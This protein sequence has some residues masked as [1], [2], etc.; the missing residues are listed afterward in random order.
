MVIWILIIIGS[1]LAGGAI[2]LA[3]SLIIDAFKG[4]KFA[5]LGERSTGKTT[6][7]NFFTKGTLSKEYIQT[8]NPE[9]TEANDFQAQRFRTAD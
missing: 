8:L 7:I 3:V 6:L 9:K 2:G 1:A 5:V 4:K